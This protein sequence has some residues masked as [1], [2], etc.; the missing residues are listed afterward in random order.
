MRLAT[1][2]DISNII[3]LIAQLRSA[4]NGPQEVD[5]AHTGKT[6]LR[7][8]QQPTGVVYVTQGGFIAGEVGQTPINPALVA[9]EHG[10]FARDKSGLR[11]LIAFEKWAKDMGCTGIKFS[12][13]T[14]TDAA[15]RILT[16]RGYRPAELAWFK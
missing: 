6:V 10:W 15:S 1:T 14:Y 8:M 11:L 5:P 7:L 9:F 13:G 2:D 12:T 3:R 16:R 4:V